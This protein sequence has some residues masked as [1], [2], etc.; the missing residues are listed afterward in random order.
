[1]WTD[2]Q[3]VSCNVND[4]SECQRGVMVLGFARVKP[5]GS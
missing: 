1:M 4:T 5:F 3:D 2:S